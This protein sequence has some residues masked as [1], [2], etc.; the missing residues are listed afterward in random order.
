MGRLKVGVIGTGMAFER[1][2]Y[3]AYN[4]LKDVYEIAA[5]CDLD[6]EKVKGWGRRLG[7]ADNDIY[8]DWHKMIERDDLDVV[9]IIVPIGQNQEITEAAAR[10]LAGQHKGII[11]EKPLAPTFTKALEARELAQRFRVPIMIAENYRYNEE[12]NIIRDL[13]KS[14]RIGDVVYF[15]YNRS[16]DFPSEM[17]KND[18]SA[19]EW[20]QHPE[21]PG[22]AVTD[23]AVHDVAA[24]RH[25]FGAID[26]LHAFGR[27]QDADFS[28]YSA[29]VVNMLFKS[30]LVGQFSFY[31]AGS[32]AHRPLAGFRIYGSLGMIYLESQECGVISIASNDGRQER[33]PY[34]P[35]RGYYNELLN[36]ANALFERE[37]ISVPPE[38]EYGDLKTVQ[39]ILKSIQQRRAVSGDKTADYTPDYA[40]PAPV[41][42][43]YMQ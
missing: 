6:A 3:P 22:G 13:V 10:R 33:I 12:T 25:I 1:L 8:T 16:L 29:I 35:Q 32:E 41:Q 9:D 26:E 23:S 24:M 39:D 31:C 11:C 17:R 38:M 7:L 34:D 4:Q 2:H 14:G 42:S 19:A 40:Q 18:F 15:T 28:P 27:P 37:P 20:R 30:G 21:F 5:L 43:E 36:F